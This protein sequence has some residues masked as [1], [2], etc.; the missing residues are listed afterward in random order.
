MNKSVLGTTGLALLLMVLQAAAAPAG[1]SFAYHG[2]L[3]TN[4]V[5]AN[6]AFDFIF[7][8]VDAETAG[9]AVSA[10]VTNTSVTVIN[11]DYSTRLDFGLAP[12]D[13]TE[14]WLDIGVKG[15]ASADD[16]TAVEPRQT[17]PIAPYSFVALGGATASQLDSV[18][19]SLQAVIV[20]GLG[21]TSNSVVDL[22][23]S[24]ST[25]LGGRLAATNGMAINTFL[26]NATMR[27][28]FFAADSSSGSPAITIQNSGRND[29][30]NVTLQNGWW[31]AP[32][33][34]PVAY[35]QP[36]T[37]GA[38]MPFDLMP[39]GPFSADS[40]MDICDRDVSIN[41]ASYWEAVTVYKHADD[42]AEIGTKTSAGKFRDLYLQQRAVPFGGKLGVGAFDSALR[43]Q[44]MT[45][46]RPA[47][48]INLGIDKAG[49]G[50]LLASV[51]DGN[52]ELK[53]LSIQAS[54]TLV[55]ADRNVSPLVYFQIH[56][57]SN[58]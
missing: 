57:S 8:L 52:S 7:T 2:R 15:A 5:P 27:S 53:P 28:S 4:G 10:T 46:I 31:G 43:P 9:E 36:V 58:V 54:K 19:N 23:Q 48:G 29:L 49:P 56:P 50:V 6:G 12:F 32:F 14:L 37:V 35:F 20:Q 38:Q 39:K 11:G 44:Y 13:G 34:V 24:L 30:S 3:S 40:W 17:L 33:N 21:M 18:S 1:S 45:Q 41:N 16:Y 26:S 51:N 22:T 55:S 25:G 47:D 42:Y